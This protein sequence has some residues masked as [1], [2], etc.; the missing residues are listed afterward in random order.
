M[1]RAHHGSKQFTDKQKQGEYT[2][3][4][5]FLNSI[6]SYKNMFPVSDVWLVWDK[7]LDYP[8][9][10]PRRELQESYKEGRDKSAAVNVFEHGSVIENLLAQIGVRN[11]FPKKLEADDCIA[12]LSRKLPESVIFTSDSD[13]LQLVSEKVSYYSLT[14][15]KLINLENFEDIHGCTPEEYVVYKCA[16]GDTSDKIQ[17]I[18]GFGKKKSLNV[19][20]QYGKVNL[21]NE[22]LK[23]IEE[24]LKMIDLRN[25]NF[26]DDDEG[27]C[28]KDQYKTLLGLSPDFTG[29]QTSLK[30][31]G[32]RTH[33]KNINEWKNLFETTSHTSLTDVLSQLDIFSK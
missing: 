33:L 3:V 18:P 17:G 9:P 30:N 5:V 8:A 25:N 28:Y 2:D 19:A 7:R 27:Q 22:Q 29:F 26:I 11:F 23:I 21:P 16:L 13:M 1:W 4:H 15:K 24:N 20:K 10:N 32:L 6:K 14:K 31:M 12:W